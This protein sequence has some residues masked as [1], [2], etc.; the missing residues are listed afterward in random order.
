METQ[1][2]INEGQRPGEVFY[3]AEALAPFK[4]QTTYLTA[5][6][7]AQEAGSAAGKLEKIP[8]LLPVATD[9]PEVKSSSA[10]TSFYRRILPQISRL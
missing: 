2:L 1:Q 6:G 7:K 10:F 5:L 4:Y 3:S 8:S 9:R